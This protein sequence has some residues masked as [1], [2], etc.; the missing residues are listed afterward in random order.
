MIVRFWIRLAEVAL[1]LLLATS[2]IYSWREA[3][4][5]RAQ[6]QSQLAAANQ[7]LAA[8]TGR[9]QDRDTKLNDTLAGIA[10]EKK[11]A[12]TP[13]QLLAGITRELALTTP[14]LLQTATATGSPTAGAKSSGSG[15]AAFVVA[16]HAARSDSPGPTDSNSAGNPSPDNSLQEVLAGISAPAG[17]KP[18]SQSQS[19]TGS[20]DLPSAPTAQIPAADLKPLY[21]Y[22]LDC[23][24]CQAKLTAA[25]SDLT[26]EKTK[27]ATLTKSRDD[28]L[29]AAKGGSLLQRTARALKWFALGAAAGAIATKTH[30]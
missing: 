3:R 10:T 2:V 7:A 4:N 15:A 17:S 29:R 22:I 8:A 25:Q 28:A 30:R 5:D 26:D 23:K 12:T 11:S 21:D 27:T 14:L 18:A 1:T 19:Q 9:Q 20:P 13:D 6:L 24:A 16:Q